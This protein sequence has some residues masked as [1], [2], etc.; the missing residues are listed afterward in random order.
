MLLLVVS[1]IENIKIRIM[2]ECKKVNDHKIS[3]KVIVETYIIVIILAV[4]KSWFI[5]VT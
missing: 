3:Y 5:K 2:N 1:G 4:S